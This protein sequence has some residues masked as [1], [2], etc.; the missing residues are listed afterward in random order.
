[1]KLINEYGQPALV[2]PM[3]SSL[4]NLNF[5]RCPFKA[6]Q[7]RLP[8]KADFVERHFRLATVAELQW[9]GL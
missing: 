8:F 6:I 5:S 7:S 1:M 2:N 4:V 9:D 3:V